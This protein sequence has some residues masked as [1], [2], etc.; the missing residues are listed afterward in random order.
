MHS[1]V[2]LLYSVHCTGSHG[3]CIDS[4]KNDIVWWENSTLLDY[5]VNY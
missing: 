5:D 1:G 4:T 3:F 2:E